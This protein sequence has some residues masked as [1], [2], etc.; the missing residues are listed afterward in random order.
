M[1]TVTRTILVVDDQP[2]IRET[3]REVF[4]EEGFRVRTARN[5]REALE[6]LADGGLPDA[7]LL[8]LMMPE[9]TGQQVLERIPPGVR[10]RVI[11][12]T[13]STDHVDGVREIVRKPFELD[14]LL[15]SVH[16]LCASHALE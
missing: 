11:V 12:V 2:D 9:V 10:Q 5:G 6:V 14:A 16:A 1:P 4:E 15:A 3:L 7:I 13:A 8:D